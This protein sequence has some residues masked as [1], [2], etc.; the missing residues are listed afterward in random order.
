MG[1]AQLLPP[2]ALCASLPRQIGKERVQGVMGRQ[3]M[4]KVGRLEGWNESRRLVELTHS[5]LGEAV[6]PAIHGLGDLLPV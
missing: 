3:Q 6:A 5:T 2:H 4:Q 1:D